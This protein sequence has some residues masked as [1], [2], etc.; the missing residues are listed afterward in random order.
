M[1]VYVSVVAKV[2]ESSWGDLEFGQ[3]AVDG[4]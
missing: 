2:V 4:G 3:S 1:Y